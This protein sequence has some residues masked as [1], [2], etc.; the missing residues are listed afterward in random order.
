MAPSI[1]YVS[2]DIHIQ[3]TQ[4]DEESS[5]EPADNNS[6][7]VTRKTKIVQPLI[8]IVCIDTDNSHTFSHS[9]DI[10]VGRSLLLLLQSPNPNPSDFGFHSH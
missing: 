7:N 10:G 6:L 5:T 9:D 2:G 4:R 3:H 1:E 8:N